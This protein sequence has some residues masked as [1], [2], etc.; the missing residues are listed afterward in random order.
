MS[1]STWVHEALDTNV[2]GCLDILRPHRDN[3]SFSITID[4]V[5]EVHDRRR[6]T[7]SGKGTFDRISDNVDL[8][9]AEGFRAGIRMN[10]DNE[11]VDAVPDFLEYV[12]KRS[13][14]RYPQFQ[15]SLSP[16]TNYTG[17]GVK[18]VMPPFELEA[19]LWRLIPAHVWREAGVKLTGDFSRLHLPV[20]S[21]IGE[22]FAR[23]RFMSS[24]YYCEASGGLFYCM[25]PDGLIYPCNQVMDDPTML[26]EDLLRTFILMPKSQ[27]CGKTGWSPRCRNAGN[28][29]LLSCALAVVRS[30]QSVRWDH[31]STRTV[32][33]QSKNSLATCEQ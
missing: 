9:L 21:A 32:G 27:H 24:L 17:F 12:T 4:G 29:A 30:W 13:W 22:T 28:V 31:P 20:S 5:K 33:Q 15:I 23:G 25:G 16:V 14:H 3:I 2:A 10:L 26:L 6:I 7:V 8:L 19:R 18:H 11:N 1:Y